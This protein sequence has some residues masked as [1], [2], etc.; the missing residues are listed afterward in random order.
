MRKHKT[1]KKISPPSEGRFY[2]QKSLGQNFLLDTAIQQQIADAAQLSPD[3][4]I[5]EIGPGMGTLT[6]VLATQAAH[7]TALEVD[8]RLK[9]F[10]ALLQ[11]EHPN[12]T[13]LYQDV[14]EQGID[15]LARQLPQPVQ[16]VANIPYY[17]TTPILQS[18]LRAAPCLRSATLLVQLEVAQ[19]LCAAPG[20][21]GYNALSV[22]V[23]AAAQPTLCFTVPPEAFDPPP[24]VDSAVV[25]LDFCHPLPL[26]QLHTLEKLVRAAF[27][28]RRKKMVNGLCA[29]TG[30]PVSFWEEALQQA[31]IAPDVRAEQVS[32]QQFLTL[33]NLPASIPDASDNT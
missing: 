15:G 3:V 30:K 11:Q 25:H 28:Q 2:T 24:N 1:N 26:E 7:V 5:I 32:A 12:V 17:I 18:L 13:V 8:I 29:A 16:V 4:H 22:M 27:S 21:N 20:R 19:K 23:Q 9:P 14:L 31:G 33:A 6:R 10:L